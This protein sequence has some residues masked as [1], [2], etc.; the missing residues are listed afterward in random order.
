M[1]FSDLVGRINE[2]EQQNERQKAPIMERTRPKDMPNPA[3][4]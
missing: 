2:P 3:R 1:K 4:L